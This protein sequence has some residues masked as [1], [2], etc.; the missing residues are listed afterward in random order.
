MKHTLGF[1]AELAFNAELVMY[2]NNINDTLHSIT[3]M[4]I[5]QSTVVIGSEL[6]G[7][8]FGPS[9]IFCAKDPIQEFC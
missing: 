9:K 3:V 8:V 5:S 1:K 6:L 7:N 2:V 4:E